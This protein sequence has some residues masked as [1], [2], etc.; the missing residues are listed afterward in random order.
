[1]GHLRDA[2]YLADSL[3]RDQDSWV[4]LRSVLPLLSQKKY[5][6]RLKYGYA[7]GSEPVVYVDRILNYKQ[8][9]DNLNGEIP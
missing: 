6:S 1:M 3:G 7:R 4:S 9:L 8:I 5:Y 2:M